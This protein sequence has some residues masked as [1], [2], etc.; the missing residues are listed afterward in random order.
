M[1]K[2]KCFRLLAVAMALILLIGGLPVLPASAAAIEIFPEEPVPVNP[3]ANQTCKNFYRYLW[4]TRK[5]GELISGAVSNRVIGIDGTKADGENDYHQYIKDLFGVTPVI[6][7]NHLENYKNYSDEDIAV[8]ADRYR[9]GGIPMFQFQCG[10]S[11]PLGDEKKNGIVNYDETNPDRNQEMYQSYVSD[12]QKLGEL[13]K[14]LEAAGIEVYIIRLYIECNNSSKHG[15]F[16]VDYTGYEAFKRVWKSTVQY[17]TQKAGVTGALFAFAPAGFDTGK[18]YYP[19]AEWVDLNCPTVYANASDGEIFMATCCADYEWMR[20]EKRPFGFSELGARSVL[21]PASTSPIGDY[22]DTMDSMLYAFPEMSFFVLWYEDGFSIGPTTG[23]SSIGNYN[24]EYFIKHPR[25]IVAENAE[26]Y[27]SS[28]PMRSNGIV[29]LYA[30]G[31]AN[32]L[33]FGKFTAKILKEKGIKLSDIGSLDVLF[34]CALAV[35]TSGDCTGKA[36]LY[37][38]KS[39]KVNGVFKKAGSLE[40]IK[41][42]NVALEKDIWA[43]NEDSKVFKLNDGK[44]G[45]FDTQTANSDGTMEI[46]VDLGKEYVIGQASLNHAG[47]YEDNIYNIRDF[48]LYVSRDNRTYKMVYNTVG[49]QHTASNVYFSPVAA[50]YVKLKILTPNNSSSAVE[51]QRVSLAEFLVYGTDEIEIDPLALESGEYSGGEAGYYG[52]EV[53]VPQD[54]DSENDSGQTD[55]Q[56]GNGQKNMPKKPTIPQH[57]IPK[58]YHYVWLMICGG[59]VLLAGIFWGILLLLR[60]RKKRKLRENTQ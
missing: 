52:S 42:S 43:D 8:L 45:R 20:Y 48:A 27:R 3:N 29:T 18:P 57:K 12:R 40:V 1:S 35:Y 11:S 55:A 38:G 30:G 31:K 28:T 53:F 58:F 16:G 14:R 41:L 4:N 23:S 33:N 32:S 6:F 22:A 17:L 60:K 34:G 39:E 2:L 50:R 10:D 26:N 46:T 19:G 59:F 36:T 47:F 13:C 9:K 25:V 56:V 49:N 51:K 24:G 37:C 21:V 44:N 5:S 7:G 15:F 54:T